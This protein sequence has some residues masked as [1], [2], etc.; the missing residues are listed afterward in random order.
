MSSSSN[1]RRLVAVCLLALPALL[2]E[3]LAL[4][5]RS[6]P[7]S[8]K[9]PAVAAQ[10]AADALA[11]ADGSGGVGAAATQLP[12]NSVS[13]PAARLWFDLRE[14]RGTRVA[15]NSPA[16]LAALARGGDPAGRV[17]IF[18]RAGS[19]R[20]DTIIPGSALALPLPDGREALGRVNLVLRDADGMTR[21]GGELADAQG[22]FSLSLLETRLSGRILLP[23]EGMAYEIASI[24]ATEVALHEK[25]LSEV[26]CHALPPEREGPQ[27]L[28]LDGPAA[29]VPL[30][31]SRPA[32]T[33]VVYLDFD[34]EVVTDPEWNNGNTSVAAPSMLSSAQILE[35]WN[36]VKE[37]YAPFNIDVTTDPSRYAN[38]P[39]GRRV[40]TAGCQRRGARE[41]EPG[42]PAGR[43]PVVGRAGGNVLYKGSGRRPRPCA[44]RWLFELR[45]HRSLYARRIGGATVA[46]PVI[47]TQPVAQTVSVGTTITFS[48]AASGGAPLSYV[49]RKGGVPINGAPSATLTF[50][51]V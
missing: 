29:M 42:V 39:V 17:A 12:D 6:A 35:V 19:V 13:A 10:L 25:P 23:G 37:D 36:R 43:G 16:H 22:G 8:P 24:G 21:V 30:L 7:A 47:T 14:L 1:S 11:P 3:G 51:N 2:I 4:R 38:A 18:G 49:W 15:P 44:R 48:I 46:P 28:A 20:P 41:R 40:G 9:T 45:Q 33:A 26:M 31:S 32:A 34:G 27:A 5:W 50:S